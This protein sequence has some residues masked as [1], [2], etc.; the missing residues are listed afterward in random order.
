VVGNLLQ[1]AAKF[2]PRGG[3]VSLCVA[4]D[5]G[6]A[7]VR[8]RDSGVGVDPRLLDK[9]FEPFVQV[10]ATVDRSKG[11]LGLGLALVKGLVAL[12]NGSV[13][14]HSEGLGKGTEFEVH[15]PLET[16]KQVNGRHPAKRAGA[17]TRSMRILIVE[18][19]P[20]AAESLKEALE[21]AGHAVENALSGVEGIDKAHALIP[22]V[23]LCDLGLPG[24]DGFEVAR[25]LCADPLLAR[26]AL[27]ALSGYA[28][29]EDIVRSHEA[30]FRSHLAKPADLV[31]LEKLLAEIEADLARDGRHV[32]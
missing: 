20:D 17:A 6:Q 3:C 14:A 1:N 24:L 4:A 8:V 21:L 22:D 10:Q 16:S 9:L 13:A 32:A 2:T 23:V 26:T 30:G 25:R 11:G 15:L 27:V 19:N 29:P 31:V 18:D 28:S 5:E 12:H 7:T